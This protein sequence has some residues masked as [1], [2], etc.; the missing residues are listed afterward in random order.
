[1]EFLDKTNSPPPLG[2]CDPFSGTCTP[3]L[4]RPNVPRMRGGLHCDH[5]HI[6]LNRFGLLT[7]YSMGGAGKAEWGRRKGW[8]WLGFGTAQVTSQEMV[9]GVTPGF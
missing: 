1:V 2:H 3:T 8:W 4:V 9:L 6:A 7:S 5:R